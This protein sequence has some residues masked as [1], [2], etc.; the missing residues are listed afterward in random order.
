MMQ[1]DR[2]IGEDDLQAY[3]DGRLAPERSAD[4]EAFLAEHPEEADRI[5]AHREQR[6]ALRDLLAFKTKG[7]IPARLRVAAIAEEVQRTRRQSLVRRLSAVAAAA[8]WLAIGALTGWYGNSLMRAPVATQTADLRGGQPMVEDAFSAY[9]T[10]VSEVVHPVEVDANH[11]AHLVQ[12]LSKRL[13]VP[14][15]APDLSGQDF[16]L[17][18]G[19]LLPAG[20]GPAA[21]FMYDDDAG[22]RLTLYARMGQSEDTSFRFASDDKGVSAFYWQDAGMGY[23]LIG[24]IDRPHLLAIAEAVY[25]Q[26]D[27][28]HAA[29]P[30]APSAT[31]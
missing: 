25:H 13:G 14:L 4:V 3:V 7:P 21:M 24:E 1:R 26:L 5:A 2:P 8:G 29:I 20:N 18:G 6:D 31:F 27:A 9:R 17:M 30:A 28:P 10:F 12:W 16:R 15:A 22:T 23:V 19:R 11:E